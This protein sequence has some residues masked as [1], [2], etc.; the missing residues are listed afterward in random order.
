M[1]FLGC[2]IVADSVYGHRHPTI[3]L[4]RH[5]LHAASLFVQLP[6]DQERRKFEAPL[7]AELAAA[8]DELRKGK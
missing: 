2:P 8:L 7:P 6:G 5:F 1:A 4:N 3:D